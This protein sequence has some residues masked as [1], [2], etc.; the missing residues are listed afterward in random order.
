MVIS[1]NDTQKTCNIEIE[2][3]A[4]TQ[5]KSFKYLGTTITA[6]GKSNIEVMI[7]VAQAK[8][9]FHK[10]KNILC[11]RALSLEIRK[12]VLQTHIKPILLYGSESL[13]INR[14]MEKHVES[15]EIWF[16][17][18][19]MR[20]PWTAMKTNTDILTEANEQRHIIAD[21]RRSQ[22]K[23]I[24]HV[25]RKKKLKDIVATLKIS[26]KIDRARQREK[27]LDSMTSWMRRKTATELI[28]S[29]WDPEMWRGV[30]ANAY[31]QGIG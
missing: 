9:A 5:V 31:R 22:A 19:M 28:S 30:T 3:S 18:R 1:K 26:G 24:G 14:Q 10:R 15:T 6:D 8:A 20:I 16:L 27:I 7:R 12:P 11:N 29:T 2:E 21:L 17:R 13:T 4:L 23:C 25:L